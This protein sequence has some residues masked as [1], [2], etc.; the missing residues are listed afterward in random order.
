MLN[1]K[2]IDAVQKDTLEDRAFGSILGAFA[3]DACGSFLEF[4]KK[5]ANTQE[6]NECMK[7]TGGGPHNNGPGQI[8]D[9]SEMAM[10]LMQGLIESN[11]DRTHPM[12]DKVMNINKVGAAYCDWLNSN[13]YDIGGTCRKALT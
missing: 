1:F 10:G 3:A 11:V 4:T 5:V 12:D 13:P 6:M 9:D 2:I 7:M 8:T